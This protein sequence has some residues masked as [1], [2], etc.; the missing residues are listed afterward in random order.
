MDLQ[1]LVLDVGMGHALQPFLFVGRLVSIHKFLHQAAKPATMRLYL[2]K[3]PVCTS[4]NRT[5]LCAL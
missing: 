3:L 5:N 1:H 2:S 4:G